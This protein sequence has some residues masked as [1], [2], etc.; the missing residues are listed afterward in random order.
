VQVGQV[1]QAELDILYPH[2]KECTLGRA[3]QR[4]GSP[5]SRHS[6]PQTCT[7]E[8]S[9]ATASSVTRHITSSDTTRDIRTSQVAPWTQPRTPLNKSATPSRDLRRPGIRCAPS[10]K[11]APLQLSPPR[12]P[13]MTNAHPPASADNS[14]SRL[15]KSDALGDLFHSTEGFKAG[16]DF[17]GR[18]QVAVDDGE[19]HVFWDTQSLWHVGGILI[20]ESAPLDQVVTTWQP[21]KRGVQGHFTNELVNEA[22]LSRGC[23]V[24][25][26]ILL[27]ERAL[28]D[29]PFALDVVSAEMRA[30]FTSKFVWKKGLTGLRAE[31][32]EELRVYRAREGGNVYGEYRGYP[33]V[34]PAT[35]IQISRKVKKQSLTMALDSA[36]ALGELVAKLHALAPKAALRLEPRTALLDSVGREGIAKKKSASLRS[37]LQSAFAA[38]HERMEE[39]AAAL[40]H[41]DDMLQVLAPLPQWVDAPQAMSW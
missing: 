36:E 10:A 27:Q 7:S 2:F 14:A 8:L 30:T 21:A 31:R 28:K 24:D 34:V 11:E 15:K 1:D 22:K 5:L 20:L 38:A 4:Q 37:G 13:R 16:K 29:K 19:Q 26:M 3:G 6:T 9:L 25:E 41:E 32:G 40:G 39:L 18:V 35:A 17:L 23:Q 12:T 33:G